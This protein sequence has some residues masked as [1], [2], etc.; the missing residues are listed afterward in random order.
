MV[1]PLFDDD[2][3]T[4][5]ANKNNLKSLGLYP[6]ETQFVLIPIDRF[7][8]PHYAPYSAFHGLHRDR[9]RNTRTRQ[10]PQE[11]TRSTTATRRLTNDRSDRN[12]T[13]IQRDLTRVLRNPFIKPLSLGPLLPT[14]RNLT[15]AHS[16]LCT[17]SSTTQFQV[18]SAI[19]SHGQPL[20]KLAR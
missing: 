11:Q 17:C 9:N 19:H 6:I 18:I 20:F 13:S 1:F 8:V 2:I 12:R 5:G 16:V 7:T 10:H 3:E 15:L 4:T 14:T